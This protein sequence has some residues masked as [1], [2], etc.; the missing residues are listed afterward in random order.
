MSAKIKLGKEVRVNQKPNHKLE[1]M[2]YCRIE[3]P[4]DVAPSRH[5]SIL[6]AF[7]D[8]E[9]LDNLSSFATSNQI[10]TEIF[11]Y[12]RFFAEHGTLLKVVDRDYLGSEEWSTFFEF[13]KGIKETI[14][15][16]DEN[17]TFPISE[18]W[19]VHYLDIKEKDYFEKIVSLIYQ[20][21]LIKNQEYL[22]KKTMLQD[23]DNIFFQH[24]EFMKDGIINE[25][26]YFSKP[27]LLWVLE[28][29]NVPSDVND[30]RAYF[31][32]PASYQQGTH[33]QWKQD[34]GPICLISS[35][36]KENVTFVNGDIDSTDPI[37][38]DTF[39]MEFSD[40][41]SHNWRCHYTIP[42]GEIAV[43]VFN[44][45]QQENSNAALAELFRETVL[46][47]IHILNPHIVIFAGTFNL[48]FK[49]KQKRKSL[50]RCY[51][52]D[53]HLYIDTAAPN[54]KGLNQQ[55]YFQSLVSTALKWYKKYG[56]SL[57]ELY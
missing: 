32:N 53:K 20:E 40:Y 3:N 10:A 46:R 16:L 41:N 30:L 49:D 44:K 29:V 6:C 5:Y 19:R 31:R 28:S 2:V 23:F 8:K 14:I 17:R 38:Y 7:D 55:L 52:S 50:V 24:P 9:L 54:Q 37:D 57:V 21:M 13:S 47:Q 11:A 15:I 43:I 33:K 26:H 12:D 4:I 45:M 27:T 42:F 35:S 51:Q 56:D 36:I 48:I 18:K 34:W 39:I 25:S 1:G 22:I